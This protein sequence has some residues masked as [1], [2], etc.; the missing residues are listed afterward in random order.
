MFRLNG[1]FQDISGA[2]MRP[3]QPPE[4]EKQKQKKEKNMIVCEFRKSSCKIDVTYTN[5]Q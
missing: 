4:D 5:E 3:M 1:R 2:W